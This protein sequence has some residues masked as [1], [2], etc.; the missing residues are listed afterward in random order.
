MLRLLQSGHWNATVR[1][2][3][4]SNRKVSH[5]SPKE[6]PSKAL[7]RVWM[8]MLIS[9]PQMLRISLIRSRGGGEVGRGWEVL[10]WIW[11]WFRLVLIINFVYIAYLLFMRLFWCTNVSMVLILLLINL[12]DTFSF[13][14]SMTA[15]NSSISNGKFTTIPSSFK[16]WLMWW[17]HDNSNV[18]S[19]ASHNFTW[20]WT[21]VWNDG[22]YLNLHWPQFSNVRN[23]QTFFSKQLNGLVV[24]SP[25]S[26][27]LSS[28]SE[29]ESLDLPNVSAI[30]WASVQIGA[31]W[32][33]SRGCWNINS[34]TAQCKIISAVQFHSGIV[35]LCTE[36]QKSF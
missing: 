31:M 29:S 19:C 24:S 28:I 34:S 2:Y 3:W 25:P 4:E 5:Q 35:A 16:S 18:T 17:S 9:G 6:P 22:W 13:I 15:E 23:F 11:Q 33:W 20:W 7:S 21:A 26:S 1:R 36:R 8:N 14:E 30:S 12:P 27:L 32:F 10:L